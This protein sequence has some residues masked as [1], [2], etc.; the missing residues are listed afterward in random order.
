MER[1]PSDHKKK[2]RPP[3]RK[4]PNP[5][6]HSMHTQHHQIRAMNEHREMPS[7]KNIMKQYQDKVASINFRHD[8]L[9]RQRNANYQNE[10]QRIKGQLEHTVVRGENLHRLKHR[11]TDLKNMLQTGL[12]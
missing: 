10:Y 6:S 3:R 2:K 5:E 9:L 7:N 11:M 1:S 12:N 8:M 4:L